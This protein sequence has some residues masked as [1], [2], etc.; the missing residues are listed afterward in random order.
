MRFI[1]TIR[2]YNGTQLDVQRANV[3]DTA[4]ALYCDADHLIEQMIGLREETQTQ[5]GPIINIR[6][7]KDGQ[8]YSIRS[9]VREHTNVAEE[10][11]QMGV[12]A[13]CRGWRRAE[14][15]LGE[16]ANSVKW[17]IRKFYQPQHM[18]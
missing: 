14:Q 9:A 17:F 15:T 6:I 8:T 3:P 13:L 16:V 5:F 1:A 7:L 10:N 11:T 12:V 2:M 18:E 4:T